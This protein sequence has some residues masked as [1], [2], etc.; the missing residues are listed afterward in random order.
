MA[1]RQLA[2]VVRHIRKPAAAA[3]AAPGL[4]ISDY[5]WGKAPG[6]AG[7]AVIRARPGGR[8]YGKIVS[9]VLAKA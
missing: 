1:A 4:A 3:V 7:S 9:A 5:G 2:S 6:V 8:R